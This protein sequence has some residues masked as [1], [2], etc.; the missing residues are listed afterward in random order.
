MSAILLRDV[1]ERRMDE[2]ILTLTN[3]LVAGKLTH[4]KYLATCAEIHACKGLKQDVSDEVKKMG[5][6]SK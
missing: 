6:V 3:M 4:E 1:L 5:R 2:K